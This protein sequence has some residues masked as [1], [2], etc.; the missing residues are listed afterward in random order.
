MTVEHEVTGLGSDTQTLTV[1]HNATQIHSETAEGWTGSER[2]DVALEAIEK[3]AVDE[4]QSNGFS[5]RLL[6][7]LRGAIF[8]NIQPR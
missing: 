1:Y 6:Q 4:Y 2:H 3:A 5:Q 7:M 8:E